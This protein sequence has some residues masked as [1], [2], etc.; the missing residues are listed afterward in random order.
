MS[1]FMVTWNLNKERASYDQA[2]R[3]LI[4]HLERYPNVSDS[5]LESVRWISS[6][7]AA[8]EIY[9]DLRPK[10]DDNDRIFVTKVVNGDHQGW[11]GVEV[12][13]W[14]TARL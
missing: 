12:C 9:D 6:T 7:A 8:S 2:R 10:L 3:T 1:V 4:K 13:D 5:G 14:I 11:L